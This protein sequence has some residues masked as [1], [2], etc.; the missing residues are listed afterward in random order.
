ML[1]LLG[2]GVLI[3]GFLFRANPL[4]V[5]VA[6]VL[7]T[8]LTSGHG[9]VE[10]ISAFGKAFNDNRYVSIVWL[11]LPVIGV[12]EW[13]GLPQ[14]M[15]DLIGRVRV[16]TSG[17]FIAGYFLFRQI[18]VALGLGFGGQVQMVRPIIAP[19]AEAAAER[20]AVVLNEKTRHLIRAHAAAAEN[21]AMFFG[22]NIFVA[23]GSNLLM[24]GFLEQNGIAV[25]TLQLSLWAIP[26]ALLAMLI[27]GTRLMLLDRRLRSQNSV[28]RELELTHD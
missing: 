5:I 16:V 10:T 27:H 22:E 9:L 7:V 6:S 11:A 13:A 2:I 3:V 4:L 20:T 18:G 23:C 19:M 21:I 25:Q 15:R 28:P 26:V 24:K 17:R 12:L 14:H 1:A 8:G